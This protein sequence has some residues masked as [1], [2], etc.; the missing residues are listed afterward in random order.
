MGLTRR[1]ICLITNPRLLICS[2]NKGQ[3]NTRCGLPNER[4]LVR[5][6]S[7]PYR[8]TK[9]SFAVWQFAVCRESMM[10]NSRDQKEISNSSTPTNASINRTIAK[11]YLS[12]RRRT[13][14]FQSG[15]STLSTIQRAI[16]G[17]RRCGRT[18]DSLQRA[19]SISSL[20]HRT[21]HASRR[22]SCAVRCERSGRDRDCREFV[23]WSSR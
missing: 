1:R 23:R 14:H 5:S 20:R 19:G 12:P 17:R 9:K 2:S 8:F 3:V 13:S 11:S 22:N 15:V 18:R 16:L 10:E 21:A 6:A 4:Y 7:C